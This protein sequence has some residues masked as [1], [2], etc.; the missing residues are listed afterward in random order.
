MEA[1]GVSFLKMNWVTK[2]KLPFFIAFLGSIAGLLYWHFIG[3]ASGTCGITAN[4]ESSM[5][6]GTIIGWFI[7]DIAKSKTEK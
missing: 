4:W 7:G 6:F 2:H 3:C 1:L 5:G